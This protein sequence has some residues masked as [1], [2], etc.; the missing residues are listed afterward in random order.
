[1][2]KMLLLCNSINK[3]NIGEELE[4]SGIACSKC[5]FKDVDDCDYITIEHKELSR[6]YIRENAKEFN[7]SEVIEIIEEGEEFESSFNIVTK[8][9]GRVKITSKD[10]ILDSIY[11][12]LDEIFCRRIEVITFNEAYE[13]MKAGKMARP[14]NSKII[15][16]DGFYKF[17]DEWKENTA[18]SIDEIEDKWVVVKEVI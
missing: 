8:V 6:K 11:I 13:A 17:A 2:N 5:I 4:C 14:L 9:N 15:Y 16:K 7:I 1:M 10:S 18:F 12:A 3:S